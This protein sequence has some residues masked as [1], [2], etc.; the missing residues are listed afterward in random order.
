MA[1]KVWELYKLMTGE[2][3]PFFSPMSINMALLLAAIGARGNT[4]KE[5]CDYLGVKASDETIA[6]EMTKLLQELQSDEITIE[7]G[8]RLFV[9]Q[10]FPVNNRVGKIQV[11]VENADFQRDAEAVRQH[12]NSWVEDKTH[13]K[14][15]DL[16][17]RQSIG[18]ATVLVLVNAIYMLARWR[19]EFDP[20]MTSPDTFHAADGDHEVE[21]MYME[22]KRLPY[23]VMTSAVAVSLPYED[24]NFQM[25]A[26]LP[27]DKKSM[28]DLEAEIEKQ[29]GFQFILKGLNF[30]LPVNLWFPRHQIEAAYTLKDVLTQLDVVD[31]FGNSDL[32]GFNPILRAPIDELYHKAFLRIEECGTVA[33]AATGGGVS[34][35]IGST[36]EELN[37]KF[38][39]PYM[40]LIK[41]GD[42]IIFLGRVDKP[43]APTGK[44]PFADEEDEPDKG[45]WR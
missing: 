44:S 29:G 15:C 9:Q 2:E 25:V 31:L 8:N 42:L 17:P 26:I 23:F 11:D 41:K 34:L 6:A 18:S 40:L 37:L 21:M 30:G 24:S 27:K 4:R 20:E 16:L 33:A 22:G 45:F 12:I 3:N 14:I 28:A 39:Q 10:N 43:V 1:E 19:F 7:I 35:C 32:T 13:G 38:D 5:I 36:S